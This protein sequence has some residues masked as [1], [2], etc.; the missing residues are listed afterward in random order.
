MIRGL[1][2]LLLFQLGGEAVKLVADIPV[3]GAVIGMFLLLCYLGLRGQV[4][5]NTAQASEQLIK[6]LPLLF[7]APSVGILFLGER[8]H[9]QWPAFAAAI[10]LSTIAT[11]IFSALLMKFLMAK[12]GSNE[13]S[14]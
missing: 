12:K 10:V 1:L 5:H 4:E 8:F 2:T 9:S 14:S 6:L 3:P 7:M 11:I 13:A